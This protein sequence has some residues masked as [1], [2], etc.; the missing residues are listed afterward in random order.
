LTLVNSK[1][2]LTLWKHKFYDY[3]FSL[4]PTGF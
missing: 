1:P 2:F 4:T 3:F